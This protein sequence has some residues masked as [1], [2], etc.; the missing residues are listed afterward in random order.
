MLLERGLS[1]GGGTVAPELVDEP[2]ARDR[3]AAVEDEQRE[4]A[5]LP[6]S[7]E[8]QDPLALE[9]LERTENPEVERARQRGERTTARLSVH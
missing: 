6:R 5:P 7:A 3:L 4:N 2:I 8:C 9:H 1:I